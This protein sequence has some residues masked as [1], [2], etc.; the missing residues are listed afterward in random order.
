MP[1]AEYQERKATRRYWDAVIYHPFSRLN[2]T[3]FEN[4][5]YA[6]LIDTREIQRLKHIRQ[7]GFILVDITPGGNYK[8]PLMHTRFT[9]TTSG[10]TIA[11][12]ILQNNNLPQKDIDTGVM[13]FLLHDTAIPALGDPTMHLDPEGLDE[14]THWQ[15]V[16]GRKTRRLL[17]SQGITIE[18]VDHAIKNEGLLGQVIDIA[19]RIAYVA[20]DFREV[21]L[22]N[23]GRQKNNAILAG[24]EEIFGQVSLNEY[25]FP[26][27]LRNLGDLY[28]TVK[29]DKEHQQVYF[30]DVNKLRTFLFVRAMLHRD[31]YQ[32]PY[33]VGRD[34]LYTQMIRPFYTPNVEVGNN[35]YY[36]TPKKLHRMKDSDLI[37]HIFKYAN[38]EQA[39]TYLQ[40]TVD[41]WSPDFEKF[42]SVAQVM[43]RV[44][45]LKNAPETIVLGYKELN[46]FDPG[47]D[48]LVESNNKIL[49]YK[50]ADPKGAKLIEQEENAS[51]GTYLFTI[52]GNDALYLKHGIVS[53]ENPRR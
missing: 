39:R 7:L 15:E 30:A 25:S 48:Y 53:N 42:G 35:P 9:H 29:V 34:M 45:E 37:S 49:P 22:D 18:D 4:P 36:L 17:S 2:E 43:Q 11:R 5:L 21:Y 33:N 50:F 41:S 52:S 3:R 46:G 47:L 1:S 31:L 13:S 51:R 26:D 38:R 16:A 32:H 14:E 6:E 8:D 12:E 19:D 24:R 28:Q 27:N 40:L 10:A 44:E 20:G 23:Y